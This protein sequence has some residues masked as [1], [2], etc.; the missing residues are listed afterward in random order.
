[1]ARSSWLLGEPLTVTML[2][3]GVL[4]L[5]SLAMGNKR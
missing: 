4:I 2:V 1:L 5:G 3:A